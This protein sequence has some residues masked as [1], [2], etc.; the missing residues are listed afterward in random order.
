MLTEIG[1]TNSR[2]KEYHNK[3]LHAQDA[4]K[5]TMGEILQIRKT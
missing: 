5:H 3:K 2:A 4:N 1:E